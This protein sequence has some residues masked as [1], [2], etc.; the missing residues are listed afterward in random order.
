MAV[1]LMSFNDWS[2][3]VCQLNNGFTIKFERFKIQGFKF[4]ES[5]KGSPVERIKPW[6]NSVETDIFLTNFVAWKPGKLDGQH[7]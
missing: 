2:Y 6:A 3:S 4:A 1:I 7:D 5:V